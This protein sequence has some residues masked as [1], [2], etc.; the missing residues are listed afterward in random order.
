MKVISGEDAYRSLRSNKTFRWANHKPDT[1]PAPS[2]TRKLALLPRLDPRFTFGAEDRLF[3]IGSCFARHV[4]SELEK[5]GYRFRTRAREN[6]VEPD[7]CT[8]PN[9]FFNKFTTASMLNEVLWA[10]T[11]ERFPE[12]A[13]TE[14]N[15]RWTD[16]QLPAS[17]ATLERAREIR[18]RVQD[19]LG[20]IRQSQFLVLTLGLV[21]SWFDT[22]A[23]IYL[24]T[25]PTA[26]HISKY[27]GRFEVHVLDYVEN[28]RHLEK[29]RETVK[30][31]NPDLRLVVTVSPVP[32]GATFTGQ[33]IT[34][35]N[36][37]SKSTLR[38]VAGDF[39]SRH[40][41]AEYFPSY[42]AVTESAPPAAWMEDAIHVRIELVRC[43][44]AHFM[45]HYGPPS[46][47]DRIDPEAVLAALRASMP[48]AG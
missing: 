42:E 17:F 43:V 39:C 5:Y 46:L 24:N 11:E 13:Y 32:L 2:R 38:A 6:Q 18:A 15:G 14:V 27:P 23:G 8:S 29:I 10:L 45:K 40:T 19:I 36:N 26:G 20:D 1:P 21:E 44:I 41:D 31:A 9:G 12:V 33:D 22:E 4:E 34:V 48:E 30:A 35:A 37:Y 16:G 25:A 3:T 47:A 28:L 7:E